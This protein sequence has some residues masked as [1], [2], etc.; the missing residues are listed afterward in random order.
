MLLAQVPL[1]AYAS[2]SPISIET[3]E[4]WVKTGD[5]SMEDAKASL[6]SLELQYQSLMHSVD[7]MEEMASMVVEFK[8]LEAIKKDGVL[9]REQEQAW[10]R[11]NDMLSDDDKKMTYEAIYKSY[12]KDSRVEA[13][14]L[15][16]RIDKEKIAVL[17]SD[18]QVL[19]TK[20][21]ELSQLLGTLESEGERA[22]RLEAAKKSHEFEKERYEKGL[23]SHIA[24]LES[25]YNYLRQVESIKKEE[26]AHALAM[27]RFL[28]DLQIPIDEKRDINDPFLVKPVEKLKPLDIYLQDALKNHY[29]IKGKV[30]LHAAQEEAM[31]IANRYLAYEDSE[32]LRLQA[33]VMQAKIDSDKTKEDVELSV[34][35]AYLE[36]DN[37]YQAY[38]DMRKSFEQEGVK[39]LSS[40]EKFENGRLSRSRYDEETKEYEQAYKNY[41]KSRRQA[42]LMFMRLEHAIGNV[43]TWR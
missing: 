16:A 3:I 15:L 31:K 5:K 1:F 41:K 17:R 28:H 9:S 39:Y 19:I 38:E 25:D 27:N 13:K 18:N 43:V 12:V 7:A 4:E 42:I 20:L 22:S 32:Y 6:H 29:Q 24:L 2:K 35:S 21:D 10:A 14:L 33:K 23:I 11:L 34:R 8:R 26:R 30:K 36:A 37:A 40:K